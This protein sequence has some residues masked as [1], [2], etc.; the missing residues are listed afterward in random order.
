MKYA[1]IEKGTNKLLGFY[2]EMSIGLIEVENDIWQ[3]AIKIPIDFCYYENGK[4]IF[5]DK[6]TTSEIQA[7][8]LVIKIKEANAYLKETDWVKDYKTRHDLELELIAEDSN[9]WLIINKRAKYLEF[10]KSL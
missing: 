5:K 2:H 10:L 6:R 9:K 3:E 1:K 8:D 4:Y 7:E